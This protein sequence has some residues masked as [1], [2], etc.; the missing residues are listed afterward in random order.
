M[1]NQPVRLS[2]LLHLADQAERWALE[3]EA[4]AEDRDRAWAYAKRALA[5]LEG[6][7]RRAGRA[8]WQVRQHLVDLYKALDAAAAAR[9][10]RTAAKR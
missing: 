6:A 5:R 2:G 7:E 9:L 4:L 10:S 1:A 3:Y 8:A